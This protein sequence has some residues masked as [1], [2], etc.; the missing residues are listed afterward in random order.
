LLFFRYI[1]HGTN[2]IPMDD[3]VLL[4][5]FL[6]NGFAMPAPV[7]FPLLRCCRL[8]VYISSVYQVV[9][10]RGPIT[11]FFHINHNNQTAEPE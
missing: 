11:A 10:G 8:K 2:Y 1:E 9:I 5:G 4:H 6:Y 7:S 3:T